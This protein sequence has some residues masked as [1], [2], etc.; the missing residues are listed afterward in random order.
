MPHS[1]QRTRARGLWRSFGQLSVSVEDKFRFTLVLAFL[2]L[3]LTG[4]GLLSYWN[5]SQSTRFKKEAA[6][7]AVN[8]WLA[9]SSGS[10]GSWFS[11]SNSTDFKPKENLPA[12]LES[13]RLIPTAL[14]PD[15]WTSEQVA[16][17]TQADSEQIWIINSHEKIEK[18]LSLIL[19]ERDFPEL[20]IA[21]ESFKFQRWLIGTLLLSLLAM[22][23]VFYFFNKNYIFRPVTLL[24]EALLNRRLTDAARV[25]QRLKSKI[26][27][28]RLEEKSRFPLEQFDSD[29]F[30]QIAYIL[31]EQ[32][33]RQK[34]VR[35]TWLK[36]FNTLHEPIAVFGLD[37]R[38]RFINNSM[39]NFLDEIGIP[40]ELIE[41]SSAQ[42]FI[43]SCL[44]MDDE[45]AFKV[46]KIINQ[47][48]PRVH[49]QPC[50]IE[51]PEGGKSFRYSIS[52]TI[53]DGERFAVFMLVKEHSLSHAQNLE[54][55]ILEQTN[56][57]F[58]V[59]HRIQQFVREG[60]SE[61]EESVLHL[62][63]SLLDSIHSL[64]ELSNSI[65]PSLM[66]HKLEFNLSLFFRDLQESI[67]GLFKIKTEINKNIPSFIVGDPTH[68]RQFLKGLFQSYLETNSSNEMT[69]AVDYKTATREIV[70]TLKSS[71]GS[72]VLKNPS[73]SLFISHF[74][75]FL[76]LKSLPEESTAK[77]EFISI[78][79]AA[80]AGISR[81]EN[82]A[83]DL[84]SRQLP[85]S[86]WVVSD[87][88]VPH[89]VK[90]AL[91]EAPQV[92]YEW[93]TPNELLEKSSANEDTCMILYI[94]NSQC[95]KE[96]LIKKAINFARSKKISSI[97]LSQQPRRGE[98]ITALRLGFIAYLSL[99]LEQDELHRLLILATNKSVRENVSKLGLLTK[100]TIRDLIP[101]LGRV[102][103]ANISQTHEQTGHVLHKT[104]SGMGFRISEA[105]TVHGF[106]ELLHKGNF[107][108]VV[109]P[110]GLSTGLK[111]RIMVGLR[112]TPCV[113]FGT[114][115]EADESKTT[116][117]GTIWL[118]IENPAD[119]ECI[120]NAFEAAI[121][122]VD[123]PSLQRT[124]GDDARDGDSD[125]N[126]V[127]H[128]L[129]RAV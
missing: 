1:V 65:N 124:G 3:G 126:E 15:P 113:T 22:C 110:E 67:Q 31:E 39:E 117:Q 73:N 46:L 70:F 32:D 75:P 121:A 8:R 105:N 10:A 123:F 76:S 79:M 127:I 37:G 100:H 21:R 106:F 48:H 90:A 98:S 64:L 72:S 40:A 36:V 87:Q 23:G 50:T 25:R 47:T 19:S 43:G 4:A 68:L 83:L 38:V 116:T 120:R 89:D 24:R 91:N 86:V 61:K 129:E 71:N 69:L 109:C 29:E 51:L 94:N 92:K 44:Q 114:S 96:K 95:L 30:G 59:I 49:S 103:L 78:T 97:L 63:D 119:P 101:S 7:I 108:Y 99:P 17:S 62:C 42:S 112:S 60:I 56:N 122:Q 34:S 12:I 125:D 11:A 80:P 88:V 6:H 33:R 9:S 45:V 54:D 111:R 5:D 2:G 26:T 128:P 16:I 41:N 58:K 55:I 20:G 18:G 102:L 115:S 52:T 57:Q 14:I 35:M 74:A 82:F 104:L 53:N 27:I 28:E 84:S 81:L 107:E 13:N 77:D 93:L 118:G 85:R 66:A